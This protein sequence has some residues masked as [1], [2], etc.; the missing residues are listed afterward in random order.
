MLL[1]AAL[2][3]SLA[4]QAKTQISPLCAATIREFEA[5]ASH[6]LANG[7]PVS[8]KLDEKTDREIAQSVVRQVCDQPGFAIQNS[9]YVKEL[10]KLRPELTR[11]YRRLIGRL[12]GAAKV[13]LI[14]DQARWNI[15]H[16]REY[17]NPVNDVNTYYSRVGWLRE[18]LSELAIGPYPFVS[19]Q[20]IIDHKSFKY[21]GVRV[22]AH[23]PQFDNH[24]ADAAATNRFFANSA[25]KAAQAME[26]NASQAFNGRQ[27]FGDNLPPGMPFHTY[28]YDQGVSLSRPGPYLLDISLSISQYTGGAQSQLSG[29][30]YL[31]D[32]H[33][34][35]IVPLKQVFTPHIHW[36]RRLRALVVADFKK[37]WPQSMWDDARYAEPLYT[38]GS[39]SLQANYFA[40]YG[41]ISVKVPYAQLQP[42]LRV[43]GPLAV[44]LRAASSRVSSATQFTRSA[45]G[46]SAISDSHAGRCLAHKVS[47]AAGPHD[48][49][50][51]VRT[52]ARVTE[53]VLYSFTGA[54]GSGPWGR[55][56]MGTA[57]GLYGTTG[58]GGKNNDGT[59]FKVD[60]KGT[61]TVLH[62][63][64][65][66]ATDGVEPSSLIMGNAGNLYGT[67]EQG[68]AYRDGT[69]FK[70]SPAGVET[71]LH[72]F[73]SSTAAAATPVDLVTDRTGNFYGI[74]LFGGPK[75]DGTVFK[76]SRTGR[77]TVRYSFDGAHG[78][79]PWGGLVLG[80]AGNLYGTTRSGGAYGDGTVFK[81]SPTGTET[82]LY[83]GGSTPND[84]LLPLRL[85]MGSAGNLYGV[86]ELGGV[87]Q[88]GTLFKIRPSG[89]MT[90]LYSFGSTA[91][92]G[93]TPEGILVGNETGDLFGTTIN[94]G[95]DGDGT[96]FEF[97]PRN[98]I[99]TV[100]YSFV[101]G[102]SDGEHPL[103]G[104]VMDGAGNLFGTTS[105]GGAHGDGTVFEIKLA[106]SLTR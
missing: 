78:S 79:A 47:S 88:D 51:I 83:S 60:A 9:L 82:V 45:H 43:G 103:A 1:M 42:L 53:T 24:R 99:E 10:H 14:E 7:R 63:F 32:L 58:Y 39:R 75:G 31:V 97:D 5:S 12:H 84:G 80:K 8:P 76:L 102:T 23:Y 54:T 30:S 92:D 16:Q 95:Q 4:A 70:V 90:T 96:V 3:G 105:S 59:V 98:D 71:I 64:G 85:V 91:N 57:G 77:V 74:T 37:R 2:T 50:R 29:A 40:A 26:A 27:P 35:A 6:P 62:S 100:L 34:D 65:A 67:T 56:V 104:L 18:L 46:T 36:R 17:Q 68:G 20:V 49:A 28:E 15:Y 13:Q 52:C 61:E 73:G 33:T 44:A 72:S 48:V 38:F 55:L 22:D 69:V 101:G 11:I 41:G 19:E 25:R 106:T 93:D 66:G 89:K 87:N 81:V 21:G 86:T 94:G